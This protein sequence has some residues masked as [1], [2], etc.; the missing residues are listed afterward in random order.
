MGTKPQQPAEGSNTEAAGEGRTKMQ[1]QITLGGAL[2]LVGGPIL[3]LMIALMALLS[4]AA[5]GRY[6]AAQQVTDLKE[7]FAGRQLANNATHAQ[8]QAAIVFSQ[9][10]MTNALQALREQRL[11]D[12]IV[13]ERWRGQV[14]A[15][16]GIRNPPP[17][18][19]P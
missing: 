8:L 19:R 7:S 12:K 2:T 4:A 15:K 11:R 3:A 5:D 16:L 9:T 14:R 13:D 1:R 18:P 10:Q 17:A 6:A